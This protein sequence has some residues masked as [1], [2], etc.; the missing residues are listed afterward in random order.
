M[1]FVGRKLPM[2][3][4]VMFRALALVL[5]CVLYAGCTTDIV[6]ATGER[7]FL[8][9]TW[10]EEAAIG[11]QSSKEIATLFGLYRDPK[12]ER[13]V[14]EVGN[15]VLAT[16]HLRRP[17]TDEQF[18]NT[19]VTF[20][21]LDSPV[22]NAMALP[23]GYVYVTR[24]MLAQLN[25]ED[26][27]A[28]VLAHE[29]GHVA[30]RHA[31]RQAWQQQIGQGLLL[32][33]AVLGQGLLG[34]PAQN[35]LNLG[36]MAAQLLFL[37]YS[38]DDELEADK[39]SVEYSSLAGYDPRQVT[40]FFQ[41]LNRM[42]E[43]EGQGMPNFLSTHPNPGDRIQQIRELTA[44]LPRQQAAT[45]AV[46]PYLNQIAG[47]VLGE[48]PRE[49]FVEGGVFYHP[50]LRFRFPVPRGFKLVNQPS[51][52]IMVEN[53]N[54]AVL[55]FASAGEKSLEA[56]AAKILNQRGLR[57]IER[58]LMRSN[59]FQAY[60]VV[61]DGQTENGQVVRIMFYFIDYRGGVYHFVGYTA[62]Q[63]FG[64]FRGLFLQTMQGFGEIQDSR[65]LNREPVRVTLQAVSRRAR[66]DDLIPKN[67]PA[68]FKPDELALLN[69]V[70]LKQEIE[71]GR[72][73]K[74]PSVPR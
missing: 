27:L 38:R 14:T 24:G 64:A 34:L 43:K 39:L 4:K 71:P 22:V 28:T 48:D 37:R 74:I 70:D 56:A 57:V 58:G 66:F 7:R 55:G 26:Q 30:A 19:P 60:A 6:P 67:L 9:Y 36:G 40:A 17:G 8:G 12:L 25:T 3:Y 45:P 62:P 59:Q 13:Y 41:T 35:I 5:A 31:A 49:G 73:L 16:S 50:A 11:K 20:T 1:I 69:Q 29:I 46:A 72:T 32:G 21:I 23:G 47:L 44:A 61:A 33:G 54:R 10:Q 15:R 63:A 42:Q 51:Q 68:P 53:Q 52:V 18:R 2:A 65:I